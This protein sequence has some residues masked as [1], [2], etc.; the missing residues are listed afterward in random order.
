MTGQPE[1]AQPPASDEAIQRGSGK[2]WDEWVDVLDAWGAADRSHREIARHVQEAHGVDGWWAQTVTIGYERLKGRREVG[3]G[4]GGK[5]EGSASKTFAAPLA[6]LWSAWLDDE[7][8]DQWLP[9]GTLSLRTA[10]EGRSARFD[11]AGGGILA[12]WFTDKGAKSS[13]QLQQEKLP[14]K[15]DADAFRAAWKGHFA[16]LAGYLKA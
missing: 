14:T 13:V 15:A 11:V 4:A 2:I 16:R 12:L 6:R 7:E 3:Q 1:R 5:Y 9:P 8:R 10:Q